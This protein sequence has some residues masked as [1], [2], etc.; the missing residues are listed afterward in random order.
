MRNTTCPFTTA[1]CVVSGSVSQISI[2]RSR[3]CSAS[4][5][6][7]AE[8]VIDVTHHNTIVYVLPHKLVSF[9]MVQSYNLQITIKGG[10]AKWQDTVRRPARKSNGPC[11]SVK[12]ER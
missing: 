2:N 1:S 6:C 9:S 8:R 10:V 12:R 5:S 3:R 7:L 11:T 4:L